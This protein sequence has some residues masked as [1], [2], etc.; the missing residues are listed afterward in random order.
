MKRTLGVI[1]IAAS[2]AF[3]GGCT[4][5]GQG[6]FGIIKHWGGT[7]DSE[8]AGPGPHLTILDSITE[9]D[10]TQTRVHIT[11]LQPKDSLGRQLGDVDIT[12]IFVLNQENGAKFYATTHEIDTYKDESGNE[13]TTLG[14]QIIN[15]RAPH[16]MQEVTSRG[17]LVNL[18]KNVNAYEADASAEFAA[19]LEKQYPGAFKSVS[20]QVNKFQLP[21]SIQKQMD[22]IAGNEAERARNQSELA[23]V[24]QRTQLAEKNASI[25]A[26]ALRAAADAAHLS[27]EQVI[28]WK[29]AQAAL[30]QAQNINGVNKVV[31]VGQKK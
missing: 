8:V 15:S 26:L 29:Q 5:I 31:D 11:G 20:V 9:I 3:T 7:V 27:P 10:G 17:D 18:S 22:Q 28:A 19:E 1:A 24:D 23:L 12:V 16:V 25:D 14:L 6:N 13:Y 4:R 21:D 2:L 30:V